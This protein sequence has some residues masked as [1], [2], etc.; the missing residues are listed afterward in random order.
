MCGSKSV[1]PRTRKEGQN[2]IYYILSASRA[3]AMASPYMEGLTNK[4]Y[5]VLILTDDIDDIVISA[6]NEYKGK[7]IKQIYILF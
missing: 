2:D 6:L 3:E 5:E 7:I 4:G 1:S